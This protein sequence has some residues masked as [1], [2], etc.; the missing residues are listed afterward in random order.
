MLRKASNQKV[1]NVCRS[2]ASASEVVVV[3]DCRSGI[4]DTKIS[5]TPD[6]KVNA[7]VVVAVW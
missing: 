6:E 7:V 3:T 4:T 2:R 5:S 1:A